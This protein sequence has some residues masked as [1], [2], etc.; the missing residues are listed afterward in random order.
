M[1]GR[2]HKV[3]TDKTHRRVFFL[4]LRRLNVLKTLWFNFRTLPFRQAVR[5]PVWI[6]GRVSFVSLCGRVEIRAERIS[7][8]MIHLGFPEDMYFNP[9]YGGVIYNDG[10]L[11]FDGK[12]IA[13]CGYNFRTY[14]GGR[15]HFGQEIKIGDRANFISRSAGIRIGDHTRIAF[16]TVVMD[17]GFHFIRELGSPL[18]H[19]VESE[20]ILGKY[21]WISNRTVVGKGTRTPDNLIVASGS[22]LNKDYTASVPEYSLVGG[23]P[24]KL[25]KTGVTRVWNGRTEDAL[26]EYFARSGAPTMEM[27]DTMPVK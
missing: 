15:I 8:A 18:V 16:E 4:A 27:D 13:A 25:I 23:T 10:E 12:L 20:V 26:R 9:K 6:Y 1:T 14:P 17:S 21:N 3:L 24:A 11:I 5:L 22:L 19:S 2:I 7:P